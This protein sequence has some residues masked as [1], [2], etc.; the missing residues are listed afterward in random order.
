MSEQEMLINFSKNLNYFL[1][2]N[3]INQIELAKAINASTSSVSNWCQALKMP[4]MD[5]IE[6][7]AKFFGVQ[8]TDLVL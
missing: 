2:L 1:K 7:I 3:D 6:E 4:R 5:K 8:I